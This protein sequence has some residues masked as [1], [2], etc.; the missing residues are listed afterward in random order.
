METK[1][2]STCGEVKLLSEFTKSKQTKDGYTTQCK[3][4]RRNAKS[5][6]I[7]ERLKIG[8]TVENKR[9]YKCGETKPSSMFHK[10]INKTD[11][12][13]AECMSCSSLIKS[14][15]IKKR[16]TAGYKRLTTKKC[17]MCGKTKSADKFYNN[18]NKT[19]L[20]SSECI[21]CCSLTGKNSRVK[22]KEIG[23]VAEY[24]H[25]P[26]C[27]IEKHK[28]EFCSAKG[29]VDGLST[30]CKSCRSELRRKKPQKYFCTIC[31]QTFYSVLD[32]VTYCSRKCATQ[33]WW[34]NLTTEERLQ[35][36]QK[37][38][39]KQKEDCLFLRDVYVKQKLAV[40]TSLKTTDIPQSLVEAYRAN[41]EFKRL[42]KSL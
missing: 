26:N 2:C 23:Y 29:N 6:L 10:N 30:Y 11:L 39:L 35:N 15:I 24:R 42:I 34:Y 25:C 7:S 12:L 9:C 3:I 16:I 36:I 22:R 13:S 33:A 28:T 31:N 32:N 18:I 17:P 14:E 21:E 20:L 27:N 8:Y 40:K 41:L 1:K 4:C 5:R 38:R 19:D 37:Y